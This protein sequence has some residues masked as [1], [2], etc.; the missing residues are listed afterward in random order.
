MRDVGAVLGAQVVL[1]H[2]IL[3]TTSWTYSIVTK[4]VKWV[5]NSWADSTFEP[6]KDLPGTH[7]TSLLESKYFF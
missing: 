6:L 1:T 3:V 5:K 7:K 2:F 4:D